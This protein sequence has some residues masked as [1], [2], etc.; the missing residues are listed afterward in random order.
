MRLKQASGKPDFYQKVEGKQCNGE[1]I[2]RMLG[3]VFFMYKPT[4]SD[5]WCETYLPGKLV[6]CQ[7]ECEE[8]QFDFAQVFSPQGA[9]PQ[10][11][12]ERLGGW[13]P[14]TDMTIFCEDMKKSPEDIFVVNSTV[15][16]QKTNIKGKGVSQLLRST[17]K[18]Y[19]IFLYL[20]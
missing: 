2:Y 12:N 20:F 17:S 6:M 3:D 18:I 7:A 16:Q 9:V 4:D 11:Y 5:L 14:L 15:E 10:E 1:P 8:I 19:L 13:Y